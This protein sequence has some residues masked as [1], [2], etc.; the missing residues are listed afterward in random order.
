MD[1]LVSVTLH[2]ALCALA[3]PPLWGASQPSTS[4]PGK[5]SHSTGLEVNELQP[6]GKVRRVFVPGAQGV[7]SGRS[8]VNY[9]F[10]YPVSDHTPAVWV[11][12]PKARGLS[13]GEIVTKC[14][15]QQQ[16]NHAQMSLTLLCQQARA[17]GAHLQP[18]SL[19]LLS[20]SAP[21]A[22]RARQCEIWHHQTP[23]PGITQSAHQTLHFLLREQERIK[24]L[25]GDWQENP[26]GLRKN[27]QEKVKGIANRMGDRQRST[28][29]RRGAPLPWHART[30]PRA[31]SLPRA[32]ENIPTP[33]VN[34]DRKK[35]G[36][37]KCHLNHK[38]A[39]I[40]IPSS[41][42]KSNNNSS[43]PHVPIKTEWCF[44]Q[45]TGQLPFQKPLQ[46]YR[47]APLHSAT[48]QSVN[49]H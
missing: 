2:R 15:L 5:G 12:S 42:T 27:S 25:A 18:Q 4:L 34:K 6:L 7:T 11:A 26:Q 36:K 20:C 48:K 43:A 3:S 49:K 44:L 1:K 21:L 8:A 47:A 9:L 29:D 17:T 33:L 24:K 28:G 35:Q 45:Y 10:P 40:F 39:E 32:K 14:N 13:P 22:A 38:W 30:L 16:Q 46:F 41:C 31:S 37:R 19:P 23:S